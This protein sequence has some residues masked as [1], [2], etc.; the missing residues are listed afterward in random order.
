MISFKKL[1]VDLHICFFKEKGEIYGI[2]EKDKN[3]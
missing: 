2:F 1:A 3:L